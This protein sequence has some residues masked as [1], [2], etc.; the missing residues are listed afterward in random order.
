MLWKFCGNLFSQ[1]LFDILQDYRD[2]GFT[3]DFPEINI[4]DG[5]LSN[6]FA[7]IKFVLKEHF[8][9]RPY[10][11]LW[12]M[13]YKLT[14][15]TYK[16]KKINNRWSLEV[17]IQ[18]IIYQTKTRIFAIR[19]FLNNISWINFSNSSFMAVKKKRISHTV[20]ITFSMRK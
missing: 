6:A 17:I 9:S 7:A 8:F 19:N 2:V 12:R 5:N 16:N 3:K 11:V 14:L 1:F 4:R 20:S 18:K 10:F 13:I 15:F